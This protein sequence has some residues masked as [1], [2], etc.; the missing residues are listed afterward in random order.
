MS[1]ENFKDQNDLESSLLQQFSCMSTSNKDDLINEFQRLLA[2]N[3]LNVEEC[4]FF[5]EMNNYN[6]QQAI[7][8]YFDYDQH[9]LLQ[10]PLPIVSFIGDV[11][12]GEGEEV[13]PNARFVKTWKI[14][15]SGIF[16][17]TISILLLSYIK[18][19]FFFN[20]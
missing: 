16:R 12:I 9:K 17:N 11:T 6:L 19:L 8:S 1:L 4:T 7:C 13:G 20:S 5:L 18:F 3:Q 14:A 15:N 10:Q 2:P